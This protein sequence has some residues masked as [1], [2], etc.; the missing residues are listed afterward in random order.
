VLTAAVV[1]FHQRESGHWLSC[2]IPPLVLLGPSMQM[3][4]GPGSWLISTS[5]HSGQMSS[6]IPSP[7]TTPHTHL[8]PDW[9]ASFAMWSLF[10]RRPFF[11]SLCL[12]NAHL[13]HWR[14]ARQRASDNLNIAIIFL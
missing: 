10:N 1:N 6:C 11:L 8:T 2:F 4:P 3:T 14:E 5:Y 12:A 9:A 7:H 13:S